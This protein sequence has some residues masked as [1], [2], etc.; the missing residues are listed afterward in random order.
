MRDRILV[1]LD[2]SATAEAALAYAELLP[3]AKVRLLQVE[4]DSKGPAPA[5]ESE[6][7]AWRA[8]RAA[9]ARAYLERVSDTLRQQGRTVETAFEFGDPADWI[10]AS[11]SDADLIVMTTAGRGSGGRALFGAVADRVARHAQTPTLLVRATNAAP[12]PPRIAR[13]IVPLD[14]SALAKQALPAAIMLANDL[15]VPI[16]L[17]RVIDTDPV[18]ATVEAGILAGA[19]YA[20]A[21]DE[22]RRQAEAE[23]D[24][25]VLALRNQDIAASAEIRA[26]LPALELL[27]AIAPTDLVVMTTH[28]RAG[29]SRWLL[30]SVAEKIVR[31]AAAPVMLVRA[32]S[33]S[34]P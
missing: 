4:P 21:Q 26:G 25:Q 29:L 18:R 27:D 31:E 23:L 34:A 19:A 30:G 6:R 12:G 13:V 11:A 7:E 14:G 9:D 20:R 15:G 3:S 16:H 24:R 33:P 17:V 5:R 10:I 1:P 8:A 22:L 2:G 28:G 32:A